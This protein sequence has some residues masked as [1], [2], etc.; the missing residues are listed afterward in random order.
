LIDYVL[1]PLLVQL[2]GQQWETQGRPLSVLLQGRDVKE[3]RID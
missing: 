3:K 1:A 2:R